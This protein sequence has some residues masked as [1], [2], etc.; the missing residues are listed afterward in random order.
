MARRLTT[1]LAADIAAFSRLVGIDEEGTIATQRAHRSELIDPLIARHGGR[2]ANTGGDSLLIEFPSAVEAVRMAV[3]MQ[4]GMHSR[5]A[6]T[7][8]DRR[9]LYRIG[10]N[11]GDVL[12]EGDDLLG[13]GVN[14]AARLEALAPPGSIVL[15]RSVRDNVRD[16]M[17]IDL[18][19]LGE[20]AVKNIARPVRAFQVLREDETP[21]RI[22]APPKRRQWALAAVAAALA[23][24]VGGWTYWQTQRPDFEPADPAQMAFALPEEPSIAVLPFENLSADPSTDY[25]GDGM[26]EAVNSRLVLSPDLLVIAGNSAA[27]YKGKAT[28]VNEIAEQLGVQ[29]LLKGSVQQG[30]QNL[31]VTA[32]LVDA[33]D[34]RYLW[35]DIYDRQLSDIFSIQDEISV[36]VLKALQ[37]RL[38]NESVVEGQRTRDLFEYVEYLKWRVNSTKFN[39]EG[40][41]AAMAVGK[42]LLAARPDSAVANE[43]TGMSHYVH[44]IIHP[45][46]SPAEY[47]KAAREYFERAIELDPETANYQWLAWVDV[48]ERKFEAAIE[49]A[50]K[51]LAIAP[52]DPVRLRSAGAIKAM[53]GQPAEGIRLM[54]RAIRRTPLGSEWVIFETAYFLMQIGEFEEAREISNGLL[55]RKVRDRRAHYRSLRYLAAMALWESDEA[56]AR[57]YI[58]RLLELNPNASLERVAESHINKKDQE[59]VQRYMDALRAAGLPE[60]A[61]AQPATP[62]G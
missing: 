13:D 1:I 7:P 21:L 60:T 5:N 34:G 31:R 62:K 57:N 41:A 20:V 36:K 47:L 59:F 50:D 11:V 33:V 14:I 27:V 9:I 32:Q 61:R 24:A 54:K 29:Y 16:R 8:E 39:P 22:A 2:I 23:I 30:S 18:A 10:I 46:D 17:E 37:V 19:D 4:D 38:T 51:G 56:G 12:I 48:K 45:K 49:N 26:T 52:N 6:D 3:A 28:P 25:L 43:I 53:A 44:T 58:E 35:S 15:S 40:Q 42:N 55:T